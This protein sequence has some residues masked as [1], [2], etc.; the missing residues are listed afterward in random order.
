[1]TRTTWWTDGSVRDVAIAVDGG[2][3]LD[4]RAAGGRLVNNLIGRAM[5]ARVLTE[6][7]NDPAW[8]QP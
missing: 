6:I 2:T 1:L 8:T 4:L 3:Q 7:A 5:I